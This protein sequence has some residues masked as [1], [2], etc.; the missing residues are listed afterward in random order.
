MAPGAGKVQRCAEAAAVAAAAGETCDARTA[1]AG[2]GRAVAGMAEGR[3]LTSNP[4]H[5]AG[6]CAVKDGHCGHGKRAW[7]SVYCYWPHGTNVLLRDSIHAQSL[8]GNRQLPHF[9][10][11]HLR[12]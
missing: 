11:T 4:L 12:A 6:L 3:G 10:Y 7:P 8:L 5:R 9:V 1:G 2:T